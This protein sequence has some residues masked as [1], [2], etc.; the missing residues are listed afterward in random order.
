MKEHDLLTIKEFAARTGIRE[1]T[2][3]HYDEIKLFQP[4]TRGANG[5]RY[6]S[7][8]QT[9]AIN[10][11]NVLSSLGI[12]LKTISALQKKRTPK[13]M[14]ELLHNQ[15]L[16]LNR[17]LFRL[18]QAYAVIHTY[19]EMIQKGMLVDELTV[20]NQWMDAM[21]IEMGP[22][23]DFSSGYHYDS[24]FNFINKVADGKMDAVY[25]AGGFYESV[26]A[27]LNAPGQPTRFFFL[28]PTGKGLKAAGEYLVGYTKGYY[29]K[30]GDLPKRM[31]DYAKEQGL[32]FAGPVYEI[33]FHDE[34][35][36]AEPDNY[37][38]QVS[39]PVKKSRA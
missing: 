37:L 19:C 32:A 6:Y 13:L 7:A 14:L 3:R 25:P 8:P 29:G 24:F 1:T 4:I 9:T 2:L 21:T 26:D 36:V 39:A 28:A 12:P 23:N 31:R 34:I 16:E 22:P 5:Y 27:F 17:E 38:I 33:Y 18:Q 30:L 35:S 10:L 15:E 20:G 11:I